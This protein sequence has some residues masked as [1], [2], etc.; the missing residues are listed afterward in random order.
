MKHSRWPIYIAATALVLLVAAF[1][2]NKS[3]ASTIADGVSVGG[4][5]ISG[6]SDTQAR[7]KLGRHLRDPL[8]DP[9][10]VSHEGESMRLTAAKVKLKV[11]I[12]G[13]VD[14]ALERGNSGFFVL[15]AVK[16]LAG[17]DRGV[18][19][20]ARVTYSKKQVK[21][22][23]NDVADHYNRDAVDAK[24][25]YKSTGIG[26]V[27][28]QN[29][30]K[31]R[32]SVLR[33]EISATLADGD[34]PRKIKLPVRN[35]KPNVTR[36]ELADKY[37]TVIV[38]DRSGFKLRLFKRL[39]LSKTYGIAVGQIGLETPA[40]LYAVRDKQIN[41][42][43][44]VPHSAWAGDLAGKVIPGGAPNNPLVARWMGVYDGVGI[45]GTSS[46]GSI[47]SAASHGC[48]RMIPKDVIDL[49]DRVPLGTPVYIS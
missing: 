5:D 15:A 8:L 44:H 45:H 27:D 29:G 35:K 10:K 26:E 48:I 30:V 34:A 16:N 39:K 36:A 42:A 22:F 1:A 11:D 6:L 4:V 3:R 20:P 43:W 40:G 32:T 21:K 28:G 41:P 2:Y 13:M 14:E 49:Y 47:G 46:T 9:V 7:I 25:Q 38:V 19:I 12:D 17:A 23:V 31:V 33:R 18:S 37:P 24:L